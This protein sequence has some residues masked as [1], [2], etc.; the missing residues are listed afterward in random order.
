MQAP[1]YLFSL[2]ITFFLAT[3]LAGAMW[4]RRAAPGA[5]PLALLMGSLAFWTLCYMVSLSFTALEVQLFWANLAFFSIVLIPLNWLIFALFYTNQGH[6]L[7]RRRL[8]LLLIMPV[9]TL[10]AI[11]T[12]PYHWLFRTSV[13]Q[14]N[15]GS[16]VVLEA[17]LGPLFWI[18]TAYSYMLLLIGAII[19]VRHVLSMS[20][21]ARGQAGWLIFGVSA[22]WIGNPD[23][24]WR[25]QP[26]SVSRSYTICV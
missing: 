25:P 22:P 24:P 6:L 11:W 12:N 2:F 5:G 21:S 10:I 17:T 1:P 16:F 19:L 20:R 9:L 23:L 14:V 7:T 3:F 4:R 13:F 18:H 8:L 26:I 15:T